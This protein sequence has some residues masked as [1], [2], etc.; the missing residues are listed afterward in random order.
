MF[1][2]QMEEYKIRRELR[3]TC[4]GVYEL[5]RGSYLLV[6]VAKYADGWRFTSFPWTEKGFKTL[7]AAKQAG[8]DAYIASLNLTE[9]EADYLASEPGR[10]EAEIRT[11]ACG[12][13]DCVIAQP[14]GIH[15]NGGCKCVREHSPAKLARILSLRQRQVKLLEDKLNET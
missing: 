6:S 10:I 4:D 13:G 12:D 15:T 7:K 3:W 8:E 14:I 1:S 5:W 9:K 11:F 2:A